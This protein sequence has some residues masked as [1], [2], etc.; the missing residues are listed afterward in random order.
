MEGEQSS[1][2]KC[3]K[4]G[5]GNL[6]GYRG[7]WECMDCG[8]K[9]RSM[10][11]YSNEH[12]RRSSGNIGIGRGKLIAV[13]IAVF[14]LGLYFGYAMGTLHPLFTSI[15]LKS[16]ASITQTSSYSSYINPSTPIKSI[17]E[18]PPPP[19]YFKA[20]EVEIF[21]IAFKSIW[22]TYGK[23]GSLTLYP[24]SYG[25]KYVIVNGTLKNIGSRKVYFGGILTGVYLKSD[26]GKIYEGH[27][28]TVKD[29]YYIPDWS[30]DFPMQEPGEEIPL[31]IIF[32]NVIDTEHPK[33]LI[34][35]FLIREQRLEYHVYLT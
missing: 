27:V 31:I 18:V 11:S 5:S 35:Q 7:V 12:K 25:Y 34:F 13:L 23:E 20:F 22:E 29:G 4:C 21:R 32:K 2:L 10:G 33:E 9:F 26:S 15:T 14:L 16:S 19:G 24:A 8:Y 30:I 6:V 3:P 1:S 28:Y 17:K